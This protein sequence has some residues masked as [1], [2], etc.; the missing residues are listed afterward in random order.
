MSLQKN[1]IR[2]AKN[3]IFSLLCI[4]VDRPMGG[5]EPPNPPPSAYALETDLCLY[6]LSHCVVFILENCQSQ[7][8]K[9]HAKALRQRVTYVYIQ[10][11]SVNCCSK[12][13]DSSDCDLYTL[14]NSELFEL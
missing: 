8:S 1:R 5:F 6:Y 2:D 11:S 12:G 13:V 4:L 3:V 14:V 9:F 10:V 7:T